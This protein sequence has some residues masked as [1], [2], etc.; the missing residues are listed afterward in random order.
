MNIIY[1][2]IMFYLFVKLAE[3]FAEMVDNFDKNYR[4]KKKKEE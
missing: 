4:N 2:I 3:S 1:F